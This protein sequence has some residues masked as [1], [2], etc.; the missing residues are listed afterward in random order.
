MLLRKYLAKSVEGIATAHC[1]NKAATLLSVINHIEALIHK[2]C[3]SNSQTSSVG[4][5]HAGASP[6]GLASDT[7][8]HEANNKNFKLQPPLSDIIH[9]TNPQLPI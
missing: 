3:D 1:R 4:D 6:R 8:R 5:P 2:L 7:P 9:D